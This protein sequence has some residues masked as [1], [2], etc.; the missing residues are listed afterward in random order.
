MD[1]P[2]CSPVMSAYSRT[3]LEAVR[4]ASLRQR[5]RNAKAPPPSAGAPGGP[6]AGGARRWLASPSRLHADAGETGH[7]ADAPD[8]PL[9]W[10]RP[11][12]GAS[13]SLRRAATGATGTRAQF[14]GCS[15]RPA[16]SAGPSRG[17]PAG[18]AGGCLLCPHVVSLHGHLPGIS[19]HVQTSP[20]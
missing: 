1:F 5:S 10:P 4:A 13:T 16:G 14:W 20:S 11:D 18:P 17:L 12:R 7:S 2:Q 19:S 15:P 3:A 6:A 9:N 8:V